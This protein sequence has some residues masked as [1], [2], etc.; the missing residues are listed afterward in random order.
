MH[1]CRVLGKV[2]LGVGMK[3]FSSTGQGP[4]GRF[5]VDR[6]GQTEGVKAHLL[7]INA[8]PTHTNSV[9]N[10]Q[11]LFALICGKRSFGVMEQEE[12]QSP[13]QTTRQEIMEIS[14]E[15]AWAQNVITE[16]PT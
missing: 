1:G 16:Q 3:P 15:L 7:T 5:T 6:G 13:P 4:S 14:Y 2:Y 11:K 8:M 9:N 10:G 12:Q